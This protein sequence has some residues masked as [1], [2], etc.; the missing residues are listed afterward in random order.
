MTPQLAIKLYRSL[1]CASSDLCRLEPKRHNFDLLWVCCITGCTTHP[2]QIAV[3]E[4]APRALYDLH[5]A[6]PRWSVKPLNNS[7][8]SCCRPS[9]E[10]T[11]VPKIFIGLLEIFYIFY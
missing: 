1:L 11:C 3:V 9:L 5:A 7:C 4:F 2:Q 6:P 8:A 10:Q